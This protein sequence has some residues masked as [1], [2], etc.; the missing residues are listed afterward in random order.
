MSAGPTRWWFGT[1][2]YLMTKGML[3][4]ISNSWVDFCILLILLS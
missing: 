4:A 3:Y 2:G 1:I